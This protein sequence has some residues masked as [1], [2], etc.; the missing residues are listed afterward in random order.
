[1]GVAIS[2]DSLIP[3]GPFHISIAGYESS[4]QTKMSAIDNAAVQSA[5]IKKLNPNSATAVPTIPSDIE[6]TVGELEDAIIHIK[7]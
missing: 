7:I 2:K 4:E 3:P 6:G 1:M 5:I